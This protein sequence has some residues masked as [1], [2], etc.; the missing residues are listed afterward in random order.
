MGD[1]LPSVLSQ[2]FTPLWG[3]FSQGD[4]TRAALKWQ[5][6]IYNHTDLLIDGIFS[7]TSRWIKLEMTLCFIVFR[8]QASVCVNV[9]L[10]YEK[11]STKVGILCR[12]AVRVRDRNRQSKTCF[13]YYCDDQTAVQRHSGNRQRHKSPYTGFYSDTFRDGSCVQGA[14]RYKISV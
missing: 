11:L 6:V 3:G 4:T 10:K 8:V 14:V 7:L 5:H 12:V 1:G 9:W 13:L 2:W